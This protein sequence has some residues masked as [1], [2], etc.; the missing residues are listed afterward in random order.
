MVKTNVPDRRADFRYHTLLEE[1]DV[2]V[3]SMAI[4]YTRV[5]LLL[6]QLISSLYYA[7]HLVGTDV[8]ISSRLR[9]YVMHGAEPDSCSTKGLTGSIAQLTDPLSSAVATLGQDVQGYG[10]TSTSAAKPPGTE[11]VESPTIV[12]TP[13]AISSVDGVHLSGHEARAFPGMFS[14]GLRSGSGSLRKD[15]G[16]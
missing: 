11:F 2:Y 15:G 3:A 9:R 5:T 6:F 16:T 8:F 10:E 7:I 1:R 12:E 13:T 14:G 4:S